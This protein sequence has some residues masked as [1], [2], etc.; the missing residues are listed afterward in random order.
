MRAKSLITGLVGGVACAAAGFAAGLLFKGEFRW[1]E[2]LVGGLAFA[3]AA[4]AFSEWRAR[5][6]EE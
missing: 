4:S 3:F 6:R 1:V 5:M 2:S